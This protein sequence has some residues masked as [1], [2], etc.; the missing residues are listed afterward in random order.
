MPIV[1]VT[2][3]LEE[4]NLEYSKHLKDCMRDILHLLFKDNRPYSAYEIS[5]KFGWSSET[6]KNALNVL[7]DSDYIKEVPVGK[8]HKY[9]ITPSGIEFLKKKEHMR[10]RIFMNRLQ[11]HFLDSFGFEEKTLNFDIMTDAYLITI[12]EFPIKKKAA[13]EKLERYLLN[14]EESREYKFEIA[15]MKNYI[16]L[17]KKARRK[18]KSD[19]EVIPD[20]GTDKFHK[21]ID[22]T[23]KQKLRILK[24]NKK[25]IEKLIKLYEETIP[26]LEKLEECDSEE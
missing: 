7:G 22:N 3:R 26:L 9:E 13:R 21:E 4:N 1:R 19:H 11:N 8:I 23:F 24:E 14:Y 6:L 5:F 18:V 10:T 12:E 17:F 2:V 20:Q 16:S 25:D 15:L